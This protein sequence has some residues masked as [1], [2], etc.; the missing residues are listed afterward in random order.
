MTHCQVAVSAAV[1]LALIIGLSVFV[2]IAPTQ[3]DPVDVDAVLVHIGGEGERIEHALELWDDH[4]GFLVI[5]T[6]NDWDVDE[7]WCGSDDRIIC[8]PIHPETTLGESRLLATLVDEFGW[9]KVATVTSDYHVRRAGILDRRC[10]SADIVSY[11]AENDLGPLALAGK[12]LHEIG[13]LALA[14]FQRCDR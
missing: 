13:G 6:G 3:A 2:A 11:G 9:R 1:G 10:A 7:R 4:A 12:Y 14:T 5:P 8:R